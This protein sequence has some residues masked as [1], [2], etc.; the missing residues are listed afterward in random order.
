MVLPALEIYAHLKYIYQD[1]T[2]RPEHP[3]GFLTG[4]ERST[5]AKLRKH[6]V[7]TSE[8][9]KATLDIIDTAA[10]CLCFDDVSPTDEVEMSRAFLYGDGGNRYGLL[11][12]HPLLPSL[13][14]ASRYL[15]E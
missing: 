8:H 11:I 10:F 4:E 1:S 12:S 6:I 5:W 9:N 13:L 15:L 2:P 7:D 3:I 14:K